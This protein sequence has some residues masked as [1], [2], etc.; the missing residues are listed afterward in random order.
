MIPIDSTLGIYGDIRDF[1]QDDNYNDVFIVFRFLLI[2][3]DCSEGLNLNL[4]ICES[5]LQMKNLPSES[6]LKCDFYDTVIFYILTFLDF[7]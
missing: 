6:L 5:F 2:S 1:A 4:C 7:R 3:D